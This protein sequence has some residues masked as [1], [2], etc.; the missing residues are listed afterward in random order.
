M[1][2]KRNDWQLA[3]GLATLLLGACGGGQ[4]AGTAE[5]SAPNVAV[6]GVVRFE[7]PAAAVAPAPVA[8][9]AKPARDIAVALVSPG[10]TVLASGT[11]DENGRYSLDAPAR[12]TAVLRTLAVG[13]RSNGAASAEWQST[14]GD[15]REFVDSAPF[16]IGADPQERSDTLPAGL[17]GPF[18]LVDGWADA[19]DKPVASAKAAPD[20]VNVAYRTSGVAT[21][22]KP[23]PI[24]LLFTDVGVKG[25]K[26]TFKSDA[27]L[28]LT[29]AE[30]RTMP[31]GASSITVMATPSANGRFYFTV[32]A[33]SGSAA[34]VIPV[35]VQVGT[36]APEGS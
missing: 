8:P 2:K 32:Y 3:A 36:P 30:A 11:T 35:P 9:V 24:K 16:T 25:A 10:G 21:V 31:P 22:G 7:Q 27:A 17:S 28:T 26:L 12:Q 6:N 14:E 23:Y 15:P 18:A 1:H 20:S 13:V 34:M 19:Q 33:R 5:S 29:Q 4:S